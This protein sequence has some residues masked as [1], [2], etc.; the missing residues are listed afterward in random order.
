MSDL[1]LGDRH[2]YTRSMSGLYKAVK[3]L[4]LLRKCQRR[5]ASQGA[6]VRD[7]RESRGT[8]T[9]RKYV[10]KECHAPGVSSTSI[11]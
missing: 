2:G 10:P 8:D 7:T 6:A 9:G 11:R 3:R 1:A 4:G 5:K